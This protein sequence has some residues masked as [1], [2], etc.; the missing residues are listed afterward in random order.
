MIRIPQ[1]GL[2]AALVATLFVNLAWAQTACDEAQVRRG[3]EL[4]RAGQ[5]DA[6][7]EEFRRAWE[8][9]HT[10]RARGQMGLAEAALGR[11]VDAD[12]HLAEALASARDPWVT[13]SRGL[14]EEGRTQVA[15]H[16]G[17]IEV[18]G[19][20]AGAEVRLDNRPVATLPLREPL[21]VVA[22]SATLT[23]SA[24]GYTPVTR[25][26][27]VTAGHLV[28]ENIE[29]APQA[30]E[31]PPARTERTPVAT[32][33]SS[34][35]ASTERPRS[36]AT[37]ASLSRGGAHRAL[38][39]VSAAGALALLGGGV[40][41][42]LVQAPAT[43]YLTTNAVRCRAEGACADYK[44]TESTAYTLS[45]VGYVS[46]AA[47]AVTS[48]VLFLTAPS[49]RRPPG[50]RGANCGWGPGTAGVACMVSF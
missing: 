41:A 35:V 29:M 6:A 7:L 16:V 24:A 37:D 26:V 47:L 12:Q 5:D 38:A 43:D 39:W 31:E 49:G 45:W 18:R 27:M 36:G 9:C 40:A 46:G 3:Y 4:R 42:S 32:A 25:M 44:E 19:G 23:V 13:R 11:W 48:A 20:V 22:G 50:A 28:R 14:L 10:P 1:P 17:H 30:Q 34:S 8:S 21:R 2:V 33:S 15:A